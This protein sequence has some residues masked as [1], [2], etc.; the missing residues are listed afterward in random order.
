MTAYALGHSSSEQERLQAQA[1]YLRGITESIW[2]TA[3][4]GT[5]MRVLDV[6]CG[7]GDTTFLAADL[8]GPSGVVIGVD[9]SAEAIRTAQQR[10]GAAGR[11]NVQ[12]VEAELGSPLADQDLF[13]AVVG[14]LILVHQPNIVAALRSLHAFVRPGGLF[15]FHEGDL[16][17]KGVSDPSSEL[18]ERVSFWLREGCRLG[19]MQV[20]AVSQMPRFFYEAG[21]GWPDTVLHTLVCSG[22]ESFG[23]A[24]VV[25]TLRPLAV[26]LERSGIVTAD[27]LGIDTL[28]ARLRESCANGAVSLNVVGGGAWVRQR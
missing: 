15:A 3:G 27:E 28:E 18:A 2:R 16:Q 8:V 13:D 11:R 20:N 5:G 1:G 7:V 25:R 6:G 12:F 23:P 24:Y 10:A 4:I 9:R 14:R 22:S 19:G 21:L 17:F 26:L